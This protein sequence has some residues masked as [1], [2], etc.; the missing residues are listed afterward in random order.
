M[1]TA[2]A[3]LN[4]RYQSKDGTYPIVIRLI[5]GTRQRLHPTG[6]KVHKGQ[7]KDG[8]VVGHPDADIINSVIDEEVLKAKRYFADCKIKGVPIDLSLVYSSAQAHSFTGY[9]RHRAKGHQQLGQVEMMLKAERFAKEL[10][11]CFGREIYFPEV[12][13]DLLRK[14]EA[15]LIKQGN[16]AN[17][18]AKKF[19][20]LSKYFGNG[21]GEGKYNGKNQFKEYR[22]KTTPVK[23]DKLTAEQLAAIEQV[24]L[25]TYLDR[26]AK[27]IFLFSYYCKGARFETCITM[28][29]AAIKNGRLYFQANKGKT[30][31]SVKIHPKLQAIID[32][33]K[34]NDTDTIFG[35]ID[36][37]FK[38]PQDKRSKIGSE[39]TMINRCLKTVAGLAGVQVPLS[40]HHARHTFAYHL[41]QNTNNIHVIKDALGHSRTQV[42]EEYL[43]ALDDEAIDE[44]MDRLYNR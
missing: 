20:F 36:G 22:I 6:Y 16:V 43:K 27:D 42:T 5:D 37:A 34:D 7:L 32:G 38:G 11:A 39:N 15:Y 28:K 17:T 12:N 4:L 21:I 33:Y 26:L 31:M 25:S 10:D 19:E 35:R 30:H 9:L 1:A 2:K 13:Q 18:R 41:K 23:K 8:E 3:V 14:Y 44:A 40:M 24:E 29:K